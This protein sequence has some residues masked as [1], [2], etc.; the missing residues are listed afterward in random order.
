[1]AECWQAG[2]TA[3]RLAVVRAAHITDERAHRLSDTALERVAAITATA[4]D[5]DLAA[6]LVATCAPSTPT[7]RWS[8]GPRSTTP[9]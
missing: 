6:D 2:F 3:V 5:A 8:W 4:Q 9:S 7:A 1:V